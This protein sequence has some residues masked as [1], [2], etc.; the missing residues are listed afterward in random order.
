MKKGG[1]REEASTDLVQRQVRQSVWRAVVDLCGGQPPSFCSSLSSLSVADSQEV[2]SGATSQND[3]KKQEDIRRLPRNVTPTG[4]LPH[5]QQQRAERRAFYEWVCRTITITTPN[6]SHNLDGKPWDIEVRTA[7]SLF[8]VLKRQLRDHKHDDMSSQSPKHASPHHDS[9]QV[10]SRWGLTR[11]VQSPSELASLL[12]DWMQQQRFDHDE[13]EPY[14]VDLDPDDERMEG[15]DMERTGFSSSGS[16]SSSRLL[17]LEGFYMTVNAQSGFIML[18]SPLRRQALYTLAQKW[19]CPFCSQ[20]FS[21]KGLWWHQ[22]QVHG[23]SHGTATNNVQSQQHQL[24]GN[25]ALVVYQ[26]QPTNTY[27]TSHVSNMDQNGVSKCAH[28]NRSPQDKTGDL[29]SSVEPLSLL[30]PYALASGGHV[31]A[32]RHYWISTGQFDPNRDVDRHGASVLLWAAG[33][34]HLAMVQYLVHQC[35]CNPLDHVQQQRKQGGFGGR[36]ALHWAARNGHGHIVEYLLSQTQT[37][38]TSN[39]TL[40]TCGSSATTREH[41]TGP[42][43][44][45]LEAKTTDGTTAL[46]WAAWQGH[47]DVLRILYRHGCDVHTVNH[48]GCNAALWAAQGG[49]TGG[50]STEKIKVKPSDGNPAPVVIE[51]KPATTVVE[52]AEQTLD[53]QTLEWL[54]SVGCDL[55]HKNHNGHG[56]LHKA[57]QRNAHSVV[58]W[59]VSHK[60]GLQGDPKEEA[61]EDSLQDDCLIST[62]NEGVGAKRLLDLIAPDGEGCTPSDLAGMEGFHTLA[63][64]LVDWEA[65]LLTQ[66]CV[67]RETAASQVTRCSSGF[68]TTDSPSGQYDAWP[69]WMCNESDEVATT[70]ADCQWGPGHGVCRLQRVLKEHWA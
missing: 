22:Q 20:W 15:N 13:P 57:A 61:T 45:L 70:D 66:L 29:D 27:P 12:A 46:G 50:T 42:L 63:L 68:V 54:D 49:R 60:L 33:G 8:H 32:L 38:A 9:V 48:Y 44:V 51:K 31:Q 37:A 65:L 67:N 35:Q 17:I 62:K 1:K 5:H 14:H 53:V 59:F 64:C 10:T 2:E 11:T 41:E 6:A 25:H 7:T 4:T 58:Q 18:V 19:P 43:S 56:V 21:S 30:S 26:G 52:E 34:G 47:L 24:L 28:G 3:D 40:P 55:Y 39:H 69:T 36:T 23:N 16:S